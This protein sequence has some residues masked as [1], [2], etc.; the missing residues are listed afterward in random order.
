MKKL[1]SAK[2]WLLAFIS[3]IIVLL[4]LIIAVVYYVSLAISWPFTQIANRTTF[5][6]VKALLGKRLLLYLFLLLITGLFTPFVNLFKVIHKGCL[7]AIYGLKSIHLVLE[8]WAL[9]KPTS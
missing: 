8:K 2:N 1:P 7:K 9:N 3:F 5:L 6:A 4:T